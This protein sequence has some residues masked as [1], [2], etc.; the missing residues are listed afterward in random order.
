[1]SMDDDPIYEE[2]TQEPD[3]QSRIDRPQQPVHRVK[4]D[5]PDPIRE[6]AIFIDLV[7]VSGSRCEVIIRPDHD[8]SYDDTHPQYWVFNFPRSK[9]KQRVWKAQIAS[10]TIR[11]SYIETPVEAPKRNAR[12][13]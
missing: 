5:R 3:F 8:E 12:E 1:M 7:L 4:V 6:K 11:E 10:D 9:A 13:R 2:P